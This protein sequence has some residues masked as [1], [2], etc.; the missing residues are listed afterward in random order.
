MGWRSLTLYIR[1][2]YPT[3]CKKKGEN[4]FLVGLRTIALSSFREL[5]IISLM[6]MT[7]KF[8]RAHQ[9]PLSTILRRV[10]IAT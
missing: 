3:G 4:F 8:L 7:T 9:G 1:Y 6:S 2:N 10:I 5:V